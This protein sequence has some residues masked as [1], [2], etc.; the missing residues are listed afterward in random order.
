MRLVASAL[1]VF[2][3]ISAAAYF[4]LVPPGQISIRAI[5]PVLNE[6]MVAGQAGDVTA[7][8]RLYSNAALRT[9]PREQ[10]ADLIAQRS[11]FEGFARIQV[12]D[13]QRLPPDQTGN[14]NSARAT[15]WVTYREYPSAA[16]S[17]QLVLEG[18]RWRIDWIAFELDGQ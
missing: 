3:A 15:G 17:A 9:T 5:V 12:T 7:A 1:V 8:R 4:Y 11:W 13:F 10:V 16:F 6:F 14:G 18:G 2:V